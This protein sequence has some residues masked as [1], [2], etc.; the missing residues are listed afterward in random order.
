MNTMSC[1]LE[2]ERPD[3]SNQ[4]SE[5]NH[6]S[7]CENDEAV[8][9][10]IERNKKRKNDFMFDLELDNPN[11]R[12]A[13]RSDDVFFDMKPRWRRAYMMELN[14]QESEINKKNDIILLCPDDSCKP[15][16]ALIHDR[17]YTETIL[18]KC[19]TS[20]KSPTFRP[21][22][23]K[24]R[25]KDESP[26]GVDVFEPRSVYFWQRSMAW[27]EDGD[28]PSSDNKRHDQDDIRQQLSVPAKLGKECAP[29]SDYGA[30]KS[31]RPVVLQQ[32]SRGR[33]SSSKTKTFR[34]TDVDKVTSIF[35]EERVL[36]DPGY[37][38]KMANLSII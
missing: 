34:Q 1:D 29:G 33:L 12:A 3:E 2:P 23:S 38:E 22:T 24:D 21:T 9:K 25:E 16:E 7:D 5:W 19:E 11:E 6:R 28:E 14:R 36:N 4:S 32:G 10:I 13:L 35:W 26:C 30:K 18:S 15:V 8:H 27:S 31:L 20:P 17:A 37:L